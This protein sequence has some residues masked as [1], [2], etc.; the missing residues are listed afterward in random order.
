ML[1][2]VSYYGIVV[3]NPIFSWDLNL[4]IGRKCEEVEL[5]IVNFAKFYMNI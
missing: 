3:T 5:Y 1:S 4:T 2:V